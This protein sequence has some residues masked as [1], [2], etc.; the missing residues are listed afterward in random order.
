MVSLEQLPR[1][2]KL[3]VL[4]SIRAVS[5]IEIKGVM[6]YA[7]HYGLIRRENGSAFIMFFSDYL[8]KQK[9]THRI[10]TAKGVKRLESG[11]SGFYVLRR[12]KMRK[13]L[14]QRIC[15]KLVQREA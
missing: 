6:H 10:L 11:D 3:E 9:I 12:L 8:G 5:K 4:Q 14:F 15:M 1:T 2:T 7:D 13:K